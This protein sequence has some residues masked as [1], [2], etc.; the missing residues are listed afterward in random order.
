MLT[1]VVPGFVWIGFGYLAFKVTPQ[2]PSPD[3][4]AEKVITGVA[5]L[6]SKPT[7]TNKPEEK[8]T[9]SEEPRLK[10]RLETKVLRNGEPEQE[11]TK[12]K[13]PEQPTLENKNEKSVEAKPKKDVSALS[14]ELAPRV[15]HHVLRYKTG[16]DTG[17]QNEYGFAAIVRVRND[18]KSLQQI[19]SLE[20]TGDVDAGSSYEHAFGLGK[21]SEEIDIEYAK[22]KP[23][24]RLSFVAYPININKIE[25]A[26]EEFIRFMILDPTK[27]GTQGIT[28]GAEVENILALKARPPHSR[29]SCKPSQVFRFLLNL[30]DSSTFVLVMLDGPV[31]KLGMKSNRVI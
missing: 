9:P 21:T 29:N 27:L 2:Y 11:Q 20:I 10:E 3:E 28:R 6:P 26:G 12:L 24:L 19:K 22:R 16:V 17:R 30:R 7:G 8:P 31:S 15:I 4:I 18:G 13:P 14:I 25:A 5:N 1:A 23:Y